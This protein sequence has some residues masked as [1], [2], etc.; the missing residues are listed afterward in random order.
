MNRRTLHLGFA[1]V[2]VLLGGIAW[3]LLGN[4]PPTSQRLPDGSTVSLLG[5]T[6]GRRHV[7]AYGPFWQRPL[8]K[9]LPGKVS[10]RLG[11]A[12][13][14]HTTTNDTLTVWTETSEPPLTPSSLITFQSGQVVLSDGLGA[15]FSEANVRSMARL[16]R[17]SIRGTS[18]TMMPRDSS[19]LRVLVLPSAPADEGKH[20]AT[21]ATPNPAPR[22]RQTWRA[23]QLPIEAPAANLKFTLMHL[24]PWHREERSSTGVIKETWM[25]ASYHVSEGG[26]ATTNWSAVGV[27]VFDEAGGHYQP[28]HYLNEAA[29]ARNQLEF[30]AGL[31][32][33]AVWKLRFTLAR[34]DGFSSNELWV[35]RRFALRGPGTENP[36]PVSTD[37]LGGT[38]M[39]NEL[40]SSVTRTMAVH[41]KPRSMDFH[42]RLLKAVDDRGADVLRDNSAGSGV[43]GFTF[44]FSD[45][46]GARSLDLTFGIA[47]LVHVELLVKPEP[48]FKYSPSTFPGSD[49]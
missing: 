35:V 29:Q 25:T 13:L 10:R 22:L 40:S 31:G 36:Q 37:M 19:E 23:P 5:L 46:N 26:T 42:L 6:Y 14:S 12:F 27:E 30:R 43:G 7:M 1:V 2:F 45:R 32:A 20:A 24:R 28:F 47:R 38:F 21:F 9:L 4:A 15:E 16:Q 33:N 49:K 17:S 11:F 3:L 44:G 34:V 18:F 48:A 41:E 8:V 39:L